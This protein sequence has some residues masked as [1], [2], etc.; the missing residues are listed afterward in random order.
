MK[1]SR[2][3]EDIRDRVHVYLDGITKPQVIGTFYPNYNGHHGTHAFAYAPTW[4]ENPVFFDLDPHLQPWQGEQFTRPSMSM[5]GAFGD[6]IPDRW[7]R[8]LLDRW[9]AVSAGLEKRP[10]N[11]LDDA[12]YLLAVEDSTRV[13]ALRFCRDEGSFLK[14]STL[15]IPSLKDLRSLADICLSIDTPESEQHPD[16]ESRLAQLISASAS[17]GGARPKASFQDSSGQLW[18]AKFPAREDDYDVGAWEYLLNRLAARA[19]IRVPPATL[20]R[21]GGQYSTF[22]SKRFDRTSIGRRMYSSAMTLLVHQDGDEDASYLEMAEFIVDHVKPSDTGS[23]LEQLFRRVIFNV[24]VGNRDDHL[25]NHGFIRG[26]EGWNLSPAFDINPNPARAAHAISLDGSSYFPDVKTV[27]ET[28]ELYGLKRHNAS[29]ILD[30]M[31]AAVSTW[32]DEAKKL[33]IS[34]QEVQLMAPVFLA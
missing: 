2:S 29:A 30:D 1:Q 11:M 19:G 6:A 8:M 31:A 34:R 33:G 24:L 13:G 26:Q 14:E 18:I 23:E 28:A 4:L 12:A 16:N 3:D 5:F 15:P 25:R 10:I 7:G 20:E 32:R 9:E 17:L 27:L 21:L 22:C